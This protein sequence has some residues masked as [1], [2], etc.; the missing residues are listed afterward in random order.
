ML[1]LLSGVCLAQDM[2]TE[3]KVAGGGPLMGHLVEEAAK[4][5]TLGETE[6]LQ[7][8]RDKARLAVRRALE[9]GNWDE[10]QIRAILRESVE[11]SEAYAAITEAIIGEINRKEDKALY[12]DVLDVAMSTEDSHVGWVALAFIDKWK[13]AGWEEAY[14]RW[15][16]PDWQ[17]PDMWV[18]MAIEEY[19]GEHLVFRTEAEERLTKAREWLRDHA[20]SLTTGKTGD[21]EEK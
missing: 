7:R 14:Y 15:L 21:A 9:A 3:K 10:A 19:S 17:R 12:K 5:R 1:F 20:K 13:P 11:K 2:E 8:V 6:N 16:R 4:A 18:L